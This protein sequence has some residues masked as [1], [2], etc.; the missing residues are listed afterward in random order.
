MK[1]KLKD[2]VVLALL[3]AMMCI[4]DFAMEWLP[5]V[6]FVGVLIV[7]ATVVYRWYALL[8]IYVYVLIQGIVGGFQLW[9]IAYV[10]I[11]DF[12]WAFIMLIPKKAPQKT[13]NVLYVVACAA[14]GYLFGTLYAPSQVLL[15][16]GGDF[17]KMLPWIIAGIPADVTHGTANLILGALLIYPMTKILKQKDKY[18]K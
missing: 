5:N 14:H 10:Y 8:P 2:V 16:F 11:W 13:R 4:G 9:W 1:L 6:H 17:S 12:L 15:F 7:V 3:S 18:A